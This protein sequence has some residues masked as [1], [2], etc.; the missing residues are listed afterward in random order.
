MCCEPFV[1]HKWYSSAL[2]NGTSQNTRKQPWFSNDLQQRTNS[3]GGNR[4]SG[5]HPILPVRSISSK[6]IPKSP[7]L[8]L[9]VMKMW[10]QRQCIRSWQL[11]RDRHMR[12]E[13]ELPAAEWNG[14]W[15]PHSGS[16]RRFRGRSALRGWSGRW[17]SAWSAR[18]CS[19]TLSA[20]LLPVLTPTQLIAMT[21]EISWA[22]TR[23]CIFGVGVLSTCSSACVAYIRFQGMLPQQQALVPVGTACVMAYCRL[24]YHL[25]SFSKWR[26]LFF[27]F[28]KCSFNNSLVDVTWFIHICIS[29]IEFLQQFMDFFEI[30]TSLSACL[31]QLTNSRNREDIGKMMTFLQ[32]KR[33]QSLCGFL[34]QF[35]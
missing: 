30:E 5:R 13:R 8:F 7:Q 19:C 6:T 28:S 3:G 34:W 4:S 17:L 24:G 15:T 11:W 29:P 18:A 35:C 1:F 32:F 10:P 16:T 14:R 2:H 25:L 27:F 23:G 12:G 33:H 31:S 20:H 9:T 26:P 22:C 21:A